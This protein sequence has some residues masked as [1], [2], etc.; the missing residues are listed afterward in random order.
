MNLLERLRLL[1]FDPEYATSDLYDS[2]RFG[3]AFFTVTIYAGLSSIGSLLSI[4][5]ATQ[6]FAVGILGF[7]GSFLVVYLTWAFL[8]IVFHL[9]S[10]MLGGLGELP[11]AIAFVGLAS[12]PLIITSL[13]SILLTIAHYVFMPDDPEAIFP[14]ISLGVSIVGMAWGWPGILCYFGLKN[15]ERLNEIKALVVALVVF[16]GFATFEVLNSSA[17]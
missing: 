8:A 11:H 17:W 3:E 5:L 2:P 1:L 7:V 13:V 14:K 12:A 4:I 16:F 6:S 10:E 15:A 9:A